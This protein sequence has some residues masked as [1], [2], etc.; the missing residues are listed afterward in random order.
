MHM[1][2]KIDSKGLKGNESGQHSFA[3]DKYTGPN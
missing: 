3:S 2:R 1:L